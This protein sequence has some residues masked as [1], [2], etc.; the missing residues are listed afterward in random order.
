MASTLDFIGAN[1]TTSREKPSNSCYEIS[2]NGYL[3]ALKKDFLEE[4]QKTW[5]LLGYKKD[6]AYLSNV[7]LRRNHN[8]NRRGM[9]I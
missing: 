3:L 6:Y 4:I 1:I 2:G 7:I 5:Q 9:N 8:V